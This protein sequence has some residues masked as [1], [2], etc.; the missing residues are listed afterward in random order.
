MR[1]ADVVSCAT[2][3]DKPLV[4]GEWLTPGPHL[5]LVGAFR[6]E[7]RESNDEAVRKARFFVDTRGGTLS[8]AG[9]MVQPIEAGIISADDV[10]ADL[11]ELCRG[12]KAGRRFYDQITLFKSTGT[13]IEDL[14]T[15][16]HIFRKT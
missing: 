13:A 16:I 9:D 1:G 2:V 6:P 12:E 11:F 14:A 10:A 5:D 3:S 8:E 7:L 4:L 15:A